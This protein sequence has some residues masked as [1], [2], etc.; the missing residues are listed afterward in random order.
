MHIS[1][2]N[3]L[4]SFALTFFISAIIYDVYREP[5]EEYINHFFQ[6][7]SELDQS[8]TNKSITDFKQSVKEASYTEPTHRGGKGSIYRILND[9]DD[10]YRHVK[11]Y[12]DHSINEIR[13]TYI[14]TNSKQLDAFTNNCKHTHIKHARYAKSKKRIF[15]EWPVALYQDG[16]ENII[17]RIRLG[18]SRGF[19]KNAYLVYWCSEINSYFAHELTTTRYKSV[20]PPRVYLWHRTGILHQ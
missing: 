5:N 7:L 16:F 9:G 18:N 12:I 6:S 15:V 11:T 14:I 1:R 19:G 10:P 8:I 20:F 2:K 4:T 13:L 3:V 17:R